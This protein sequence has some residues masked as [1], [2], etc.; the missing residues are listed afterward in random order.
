[1]R[2]KGERPIVTPPEA[3]SETHVVARTMREGDHWLYA[4][5]AQRTTPLHV[6]ER[7]ARIPR[8]RL[9]AFRTGAEPTPEEIERLAALW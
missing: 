1:M 4:W 5:L 2:R 8:D 9:D 6:I 3:W 7:K